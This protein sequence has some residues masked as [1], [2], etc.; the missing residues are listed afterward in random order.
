MR[1]ATKIVQEIKLLRSSIQQRDKE[2]AERASLVSQEK[3][4]QGKKV[5]K[6]PDLWIRPNFGGKGRK[7]PGTLEAHAN[8]FRYSNP[9]NESINVMYRNIRH[10]FFQP[11]ENEMVTILHFHLINPIMIGNKKSKDIQFYTEVMDVVQTLG[12]SRRNAYDPDEIEEEQREREKRNRINADFQQFVKR[13]QELWEKDFSDLGLEFDIPFREL[14]FS[15]TPA[16][17]SVFIMPTVNCLV[18]LTEMPFTVVS[19]QD[20]EIINLER[21]GFNLK[22]FDMAIVFKDFSRDVMR[23]DSIPTKGLEMLKEWLTSVKIKYYESKLNL[24]WKPILKSIIEDPEGFVEQG[25]WDFLNMDGGSDGSDDEEQSDDYQPSGEDEDD[26]DEDD[27]TDDEDAS[28][29]DSDDEDDEDEEDEDEEEGKT[30]EELEEE[31]EMDD[32]R[33]ADDS[34]D[35]DRKGAKRKG[36]S[37]PQT[38]AKKPRK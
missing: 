14:G 28:V 6:L 37:K 3:L 15:G 7:M 16:R 18:E 36:G 13:V 38:Q 32:R 4:I 33:K 1:H 24:S 10:A 21:V 27:D 34:D 20:V 9:K 11:A 2:K 35:D 29:V 22:N 5:F 23:I 25:G 19:L 30:W 8:G 17:S 12:D 26:E 31:A